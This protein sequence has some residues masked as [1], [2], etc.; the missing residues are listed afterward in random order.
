M[1]TKYD[2]FLIKTS[3]E[4]APLNSKSEDYEWKNEL[5]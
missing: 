1:P 3:E 5:K 2:R 4:I